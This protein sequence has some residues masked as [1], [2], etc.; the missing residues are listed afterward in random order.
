MFQSDRVTITATQSNVS[1]SATSVA[2]LAANAQ[3]KYFSFFNDSTQIAYI[4]K[5]TG[6]ATSS[7]YWLRIESY[8]FYESTEPV[9][10]G[11]FTVIWAAANGAMRVTEEV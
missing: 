7:D 3:R 2:L 6:A 5:G 11:A 1:S 4:K 10:V 8:G 9:Y